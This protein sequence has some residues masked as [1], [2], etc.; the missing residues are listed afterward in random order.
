MILY[1]LKFANP[2]ASSVGASQ[3]QLS[4]QIIGQVVSFELLRLLWQLASA[5]RASW[6]ISLVLDPLV[7]A[8]AAKC[9]LAI[10]HDWIHKDVFTD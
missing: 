1:R 9:M 2:T 6:S 7:Y 10:T 3:L 5:D 8:F 4:D